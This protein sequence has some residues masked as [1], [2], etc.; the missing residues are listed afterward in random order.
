VHELRECLNKA[1]FMTEEERLD[2]SQRAR[3]FA[4]NFDRVAI[5]DN[6]IHRSLAVS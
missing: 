4:M 6:L 1:Y 3:E 5:L 2:L